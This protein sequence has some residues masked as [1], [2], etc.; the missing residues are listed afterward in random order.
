MRAAHSWGLIVQSH[1]MSG[2]S[3]DARTVFLFT[4]H[5]SSGF[6]AAQWRDLF[7]YPS[8]LRLWKRTPLQPPLGDQTR[9]HPPT[10]S[11]ILKNRYD[12]PMRRILALALLTS[13]SAFAQTKS[14]TPL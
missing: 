14:Q 8:S 13:L 11:F 4:S 12:P 9:F 2:H 10:F 1:R 3:R 6:T 7:L 5:R